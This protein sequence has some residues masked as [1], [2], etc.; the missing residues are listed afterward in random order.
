MHYRALFLLPLVA[1]ITAG[2]PANQPANPFAGDAQAAGVG[3]GIFRIY[4][5]PCHGIRGQ[6][7]RGPDLT[8]G[9][10]NSGEHDA[11]LFRTISTG[12]AGTEMESYSAI[13]TDDNIWRLVAFIRSLGHTAPAAPAP[14]DSARGRELFWGKGRCGNCHMVDAKGGRSGPDLSRAGRQRSNAYLRTSIIDPSADISPGYNSVSV[15]LRDGKK[16]LGLQRGLDNFTVQVVDLAGNFYSFDKSNVSSVKHETRSLMPDNY[17]KIFTAPEVD[18]IVSY[19]STLRG[20]VPK[21]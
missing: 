18:D 6:G 8:R 2:Q 5:A 10:Y 9:V 19:L 15:V 16:I 13:L 3:N 20:E 17:G 11:D 14:G 4:C 21:P 7:G 12:V 1:V